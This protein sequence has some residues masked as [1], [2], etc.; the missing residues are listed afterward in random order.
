M[1]L[2]QTRQRNRQREKA[3]RV[4][5][6]QAE[7]TADLLYPLLYPAAATRRPAA[8]RSASRGRRR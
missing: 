7:I 5:I 3:P 8:G 1:R 2:T 4:S 6:S